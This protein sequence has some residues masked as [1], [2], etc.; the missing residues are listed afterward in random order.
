MEG[1]E[2]ALRDVA[3]YVVPITI[4]ILATLFSAQR[5]GTDLVG[6]A[7]G[8]DHARLVRDDRRSRIG[9]DRALPVDSRRRQSNTHAVR[10][11]G[12]HGMGAFFVLGSVA[13]AVTGAE[14]LYADMGHFGATPDPAASG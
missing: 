4:I 9:R 14:A 6:K 11:I 12:E 5:L 8:P 2:L 7:F 3:H 13:L 1:L 10:F